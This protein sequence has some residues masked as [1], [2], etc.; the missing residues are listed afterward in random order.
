MSDIL[1]IVLILITGIYAY[2]T[3]RILK[4]NEAT[5]AT[6][7]E[8]LHSTVRPYVTIS[9]ETMRR[10][11]MFLLRI[12][13]TGSS[14]AQN[15]RLTIDRDFHVLGDAAPQR[16]IRSFHIFQNPVETFPPG[17]ELRFHLA[18]ALQLWDPLAN[19]QILPLEFRVTAQFVHQG[20]EHTETSIVDFRPFQFAALM[21]DPLI[22]ELERIRQAL[23]HEQH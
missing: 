23:Q 16:N 10:S 21:P 13:N 1:T 12:A 7:R 14:V 3:Y 20:V 11:Q 4:A 22:E 17:A 6:M 2:F 18:T 19:R 15:L 8:Q 5:V 9:L